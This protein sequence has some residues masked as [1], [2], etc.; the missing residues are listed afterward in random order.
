VKSIFI[1]TI[2]PGSL[3]YTL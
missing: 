2:N 1:I 3:N